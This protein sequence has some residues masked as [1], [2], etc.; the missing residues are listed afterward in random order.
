MASKKSESVEIDLVKVEHGRVT[1]CILGTNALY[2]NRL[3]EKAKRQLL[4]PPPKKNAVEKATTLKHDPMAE[5]RDSPYMLLADGDSYDTLIAHLAT[6]FKCAIAGAALD[7]PGTSRSQI[8][9][10]VS[11]EGNRIPIYGVPHLAMDVVRSA[12]M[13]RTPDVRTRCVLPEWA[14]RVTVQFMKPMLKES[15][16]STL[17]S[18]AGRT[19]GIGDWRNEKGSGTYGSFEIVDE[20]NADFRRLVKTAGRK[21]QIAAMKDPDFYGEDTKELFSWFQGEVERRDMTKLLMSWSAGEIA[22][23][24]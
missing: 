10:L 8:E 17:L 16:I 15:S 9:R 7:I 23:A 18:M 2:C 6:A 12:D 14:C 22:A 4:L 19:Q 3:S 24:E 13:N 11:V 20:N 1:Y 5:F 21:V